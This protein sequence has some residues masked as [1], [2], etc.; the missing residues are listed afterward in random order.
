MRLGDLLR[1]NMLEEIWSAGRRACLQDSVC[2]ILGW[3]YENPWSKTAGRILHHLLDIINGPPAT[4][5]TSEVLH[6]DACKRTLDHA[7]DV[8]VYDLFYDVYSD[9]DE[10]DRMEIFALFL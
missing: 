4:P 10:A 9:V 8:L 3:S 1:S 6:P 5:N 2:Q 7:I